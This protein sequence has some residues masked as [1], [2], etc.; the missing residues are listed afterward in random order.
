M[1]EKN[2]VS[3][4][5]FENPLRFAD[6]I[7][8]YVFQGRQVVKEEDVRE[9]M[10]V[11]ARFHRKEN[12]ATGKRTE[13]GNVH[14]QI[15]TPDLIKAVFHDIQM[16]VILL[17]NQSDVHYAMPVR[18]M[19]EEGSYYHK[20]WRERAYRHRQDKDLRGAEYLSGFGKGERLLPVIT[21][22]VYWGKQ[23]WDGP[24]CLKEM[25]DMEKYPPEIRHLIADYPLHLLEV[26]KFEQLENFE[27]DIKYVFGFLQRE[28]DKQGLSD[29]VKDN[30][31]AF[32]HLREDAYHMISVMTGFTDLNT[33]DI[34]DKENEN[35]YRRE[36]GNYDMCQAIREMMEDSKAEGIKEGYHLMKSLILKMTEDGM[37]KNIPRLAVD[38][39]YFEEM[40]RQYGLDEG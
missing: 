28:N 38:S 17:E 4:E 5:Y 15:F 36:G 31:E 30:Q 7:N 6:L 9:L 37:E 10:P 2:A 24:K 18:I 11:T 34:R 8:G 33:G 12:T 19:N 40:I 27:T 21:L 35:R 14:A 32:S 3:M 16:L 22:V 29:Y 20:Q 25:L 1:Q 13:N 39:G 26:R 23:A